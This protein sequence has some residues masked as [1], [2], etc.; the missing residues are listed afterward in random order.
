[1]VDF[2]GIQENTK[3]TQNS[4]SNLAS[5]I[6][7]LETKVDT[8]NNIV[9]NH[10]STVKRVIADT[11]YA[12]KS[13]YQ[14]EDEKRLLITLPIIN[15]NKSLVLWHPNETP[16]RDTSNWSRYYSTATIINSTT[17]A[18]TRTSANHASSNSYKHTYYYSGQYQIIEFY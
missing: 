10:V 15:P 14:Y 4:E 12:E 18:I 9:S 16:V 11:V 1:M 2:I 13:A 7:N 5:V 17:L 8:V 6:T 3:Q